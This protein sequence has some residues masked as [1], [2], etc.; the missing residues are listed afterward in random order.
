MNL[1]SLLTRHTEDAIVSKWSVPKGQ[2]ATVTFKN[3]FKTLGGFPKVVGIKD[4]AFAKAHVFDT[5]EPPMNI[6]QYVADFVGGE[7]MVSPHGNTVLQPYKS[8]AAK[9]KGVTHSIVANAT[10]VIRPGLDITNSIKEIPNRVVCVFEE[11]DSQQRVTQ[12]VGKAALAKTEPRSY[13]NTGKWV[14]RYYKLTNAKKPYVANLNAK[15]ASYLKSLNNKNVYYEFDT[16]YQPIEIGEVIRLKYDEITV[17]GLV[18]DI[19]LNLTIGAQ[20]H[21]K[22]RKV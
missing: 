19:D 4:R 11:I 5:G 12:Y 20:M 17:Y 16:Y 9:K 7:I 18:T 6:L 8:P 22:I 21:V 15:A 14:T 2:K 10:S 3:V 1:R 13:Q